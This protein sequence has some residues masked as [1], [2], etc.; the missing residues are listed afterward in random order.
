MMHY[1]PIVRYEVSDNL[2][3][4]KLY[5]GRLLTCRLCSV[6]V[7]EYYFDRPSENTKYILCKKCKLEVNPPKLM[8]REYAGHLWNITQNRFE[9]RF[10]LEEFGKCGWFLREHST[11]IPVPLV[12]RQSDTHVY[13]L[14]H[15][16]DK[17]CIRIRNHPFY[18]DDM[19]A[20]I[21][22]E[23]RNIY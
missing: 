6:M 11:E 13:T 8:L 3:L 20:C 22:S 16:G 23:C 1:K 21:T 4:N 15:Y 7:T 12:P 17:R 19:T 9:E 2:L 5:I 10:T 14:E 18:Y